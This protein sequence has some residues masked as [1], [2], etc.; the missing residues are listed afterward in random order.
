MTINYQNEGNKVTIFASDLR[1]PYGYS[2][3]LSFTIYSG[4]HWHIQGR[5]GC[6]KSTLLKV[7]AGLLPSSSGECR[8]S[9]EFCYL[10]Q[11]LNLL[12]RH[13][14]SLKHFINTNRCLL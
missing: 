9:G 8:L 14:L 12:I 4:E 5:N 1:L 3:P 13:Y 11:H 7:L 10:D 6:G 2:S